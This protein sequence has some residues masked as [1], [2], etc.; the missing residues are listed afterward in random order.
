MMPTD[1]KSDNLEFEPAPAHN[2]MRD[3]LLSGTL[4]KPSIRLPAVVVRILNAGIHSSD[5]LVRRRQVFTNIAS[6]MAALNAFLHL[7]TNGMHDFNGLAVVNAYN[8]LV[9]FYFL[10]IH[11]LHRY[12]DLVA[13]IA[14]IVGI[15]IG[16]SFVV[17]ALGTSSDLHFYF[18]LAGFVLFLVGVDNIRVF[19]ALYFM[20]FAFLFLALFYATEA[21]FVLPEDI[22]LRQRLSF[23]AA[24]NTYVMNGVL[25]ASALISLHFAEARSEALLANILPRRIVDR[26]KSSSDRRIADRI[27]GCSIL[28]VDLVGFTDAARQ[29]QPEDVVAYLDSIFST[30][31]RACEKHGVEK[32]KTIGDSY[33]AVGGLEGRPEDGALNVGMLALDCLRKLAAEPNL[34]RHRMAIRLGIHTGP[35]TAGII[36]ENRVSYDVWGNSVNIASRMESHG[37]PGH[38]HVTEDYRA[39]ADPWFEFEPRDPIEIRNVGKAETYFLLAP[40]TVPAARTGP[41]E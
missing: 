19:I 28:F 36:G 2:R 30:F 24:I 13:A 14:L 40:R 39:I 37:I 35:V 12:G 4:G 17:F 41:A 15:A 31:D 10:F 1:I 22:A 6:Y 7:V 38:I 34:G 27:E 33:M 18:T 11:R 32:I 16:H 21:G 29:L 26:L 23:E 20:V 9:F 8:A 25:I 3:R 5:Q